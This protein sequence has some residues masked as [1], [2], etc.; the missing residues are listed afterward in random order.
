MAKTKKKE[1]WTDADRNG[2]AEKKGLDMGTLFTAEDKK[3][4]KLGSLHTEKDKE[5]LL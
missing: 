4:F 2:L 1:L 3:G 5:G